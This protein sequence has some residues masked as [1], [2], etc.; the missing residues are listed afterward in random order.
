MTNESR[1]ELRFGNLS[2]VS[3]FEKT[4]WFLVLQ[5]QKPEGDDLNRLLTVCNE[6]VEDYSQPPLYGSPRSASQQSS[7]ANARPKG[8]R[9]ENMGPLPGEGDILDF[10]SAFHV[11]IGWALE[12]PSSYVTDTTKSATEDTILESLKKISAKVD[13]LKVKVGNIV[14]S[15]T[16]ATKAVEGKGIFGA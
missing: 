5:L 1:F 9:Q 3:N 8:L 6:A 12:Q 4:R 10:S 7:K 15:I 11:S 2:W 16:L 14:K 13:T